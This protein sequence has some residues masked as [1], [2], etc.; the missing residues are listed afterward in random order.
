MD[1]QYQLTSIS[2]AVET[3]RITNSNGQEGKNVWT[4]FCSEALKSS[5]FCWP[6]AGAGASGGGGGGSS[7]GGIPTKSSPTN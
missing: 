1:Y 2:V 6:G 5:P 7:G 3:N 4:A